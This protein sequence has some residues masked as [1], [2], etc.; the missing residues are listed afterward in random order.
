MF[1]SPSGDVL[2]SRSSNQTKRQNIPV[3]M[4]TS[5]RNVLIHKVNEMT[6]ISL[7]YQVAQFIDPG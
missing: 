6:M 5:P 2:V 3:H 4:G 1:Q 7:H